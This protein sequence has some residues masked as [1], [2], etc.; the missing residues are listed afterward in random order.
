MPSIASRSSVIRV[1]VI[2]P[3]PNR[4]AG[5]PGTDLPRSGFQPH[6]HPP[7]RRLMP[8]S[9]WRGAE[10]GRN[11]GGVGQLCCPTL[12]RLFP[13][14][15]ELVSNPNG[16]HSGGGGRGWGSDPP[17]TTGMAST[18]PSS[19][20]GAD[21]TGERRGRLD[22][23]AVKRRE[24][25]RDRAPDGGGQATHHHRLFGDTLETE[26]DEGADHPA[27]IRAQTQVHRPLRLGGAA[28]EGGQEH[29]DRFDRRMNSRLGPDAA[30]SALEGEVGSQLAFGPMQQTPPA[31]AGGGLPPQA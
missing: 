24:R 23:A 29:V 6:P 16:G 7:L 30:R 15:P 5:T 22:P 8:A 10:R 28:Q 4:R 31:G 21:D 27:L 13:P 11:S 25:R 3:N 17:R 20:I 26:S 12:P 18:S 2:R 1:P 19:A 14:P 9:W